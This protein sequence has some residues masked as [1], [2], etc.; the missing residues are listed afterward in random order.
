MV[1]SSAYQVMDNKSK[2]SAMAQYFAA[3]QRF[4]VSLCIASKVPKTLELAK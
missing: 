2:G 4:F 3:H 1:A